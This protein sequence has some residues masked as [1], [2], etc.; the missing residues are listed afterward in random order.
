MDKKNKVKNNKKVETIHIN[1]KL[2]K[3]FVFN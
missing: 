1:I 3:N 2:T